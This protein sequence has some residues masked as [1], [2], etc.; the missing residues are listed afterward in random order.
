MPDSTP[1]ENPI[2]DLIPEVKTELKKEPDEIIPESC[3]RIENSK[4]TE[5]DEP[6]EKPN[7]PVIGPVPMDTLEPM[8]VECP[9]EEI[10]LKPVESD[11]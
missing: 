10:P 8:E 2:P 11:L 3:I 1:N 4:V 9:E 6:T 7:G 5:Q